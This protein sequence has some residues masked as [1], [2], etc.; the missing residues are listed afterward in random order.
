MHGSLAEF[1]TLNLEEDDWEV[2][3]DQLYEYRTHGVTVPM[4]DAIVA[5]IA[6]IYGIPVWSKD[7]HFDLM[8]NVISELQV[9]RTE[10][11]I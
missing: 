10:E 6:L 1:D 3:G 11:L 4:P 5:S 8:R 7:G 2:L 9:I